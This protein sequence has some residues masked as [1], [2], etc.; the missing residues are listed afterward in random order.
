[1][2]GYNNEDVIQNIV[3]I[4]I[5]QNNTGSYFYIHTPHTHTHTH[6][7]TLGGLKFILNGLVALMALSLNWG[8][9]VVDM[10]IH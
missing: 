10:K 1:M 7:Q 8:M 5:V 2:D 3:S 9:E 6:I 4:I